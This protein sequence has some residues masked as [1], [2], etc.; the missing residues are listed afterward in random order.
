MNNNPIPLLIST[1]ILDFQGVFSFNIKMHTPRIVNVA[2]K[3][4]LVNKLPPLIAILK[5]A[6]VI[7]PSNWGIAKSKSSG[8]MSNA[9]HGKKKQ[10]KATPPPT[11][12]S[13]SGFC[14]MV[15]SS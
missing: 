6:T 4:M 9:I 7:D 13:I 5:P 11:N 3:A 1:G 10:R 14:L 8:D 12:G 2:R 15:D